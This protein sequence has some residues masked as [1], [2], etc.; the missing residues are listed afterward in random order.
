MGNEEMPDPFDW[1][2]HCYRRVLDVPLPRP[3]RYDAFVAANNELIHP[4]VEN[5]FS[6]F[7]S[8]FELE[9]IRHYP[10]HHATI[11]KVAQHLGVAPERLLLGAGS[12]AAIQIL[13]QSV[14]RSSRRLILQWPNYSGYETYAALY[15][16]E[17]QRV[18]TLAMPAPEVEARL[19]RA[20]EESPPALVVITNPSGMDGSRLPI[21]SLERLMVVALRRQ[22]L[23]VID[24]AYLGF[25]DVDHMPLMEKFENIV[26]LR[27]FSKSMG[28]AGLR[29]GVVI[30][31]DTKLSDYLRRWSPGNPVSVVATHFLGFCIDHVAELAAARA[32]IVVCREWIRARA[33]ALLHGW[34]IPE[35]EAN[36]VYFGAPSPTA[37]AA[38]LRG[39]DSAGIAVRD[40]SRF[41]PPTS[42]V[43][44]TVGQKQ[45]S[46]RVVEVLE[47]LA[48]EQP[49][50]QRA[51]P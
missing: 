9:R 24:E 22:Q 51:W 39:F 16:V 13:L 15:G 2:H 3:N 46:G 11:E 27:S 50:G 42:A 49:K 40:I 41:H 43:R 48:G 37:S 20:M 6:R 10:D 18:L 38:M 14:G 33:R 1:A 35:S 32:E 8:S 19:L 21:S 34:C 29:I 44:V 4:V 36:F 17:I 31:G 45:F 26:I 28:L 12:D 7:V 25:S 30:C 47:T 23:L 5:L